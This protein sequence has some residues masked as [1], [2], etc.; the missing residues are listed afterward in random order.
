MAIKRE[1]PSFDRH[2]AGRFRGRW[3]P[4]RYLTRWVRQA[5]NQRK[6]LW[7]T[8]SSY[9]MPS[10]A[11]HPGRVKSPMLFPCP[12]ASAFPSSILS[13]R[14]KP[15]WKP[16]FHRPVCSNMFQYLH[17]L[18]SL[19]PTTLPSRS[20]VRR[21]M[22]L[23]R[24]SLTRLNILWDVGASEGSHH[25]GIGELLQ[26]FEGCHAE[27][28]IFVLF[29][30]EFPSEF[31][32]RLGRRPSIRV[33]MQWI[34]RIIFALASINDGG[35][36]SSAAELPSARKASPSSRSFVVRMLPIEEEFMA[37]YLSGYSFWDTNPY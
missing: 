34:S 28:L 22:Y 13:R 9:Q 36:F 20:R 33:R 15:A 12:S 31:L 7:E 21:D 3:F 30:V 18:T 19:P 37:L 4:R 11:R 25:A 16:R 14:P 32:V 27:V 23:L 26:Q 8:G 2:A 35:D 6:S 29:I 17:A 5:R 1:S 24:G 10:T